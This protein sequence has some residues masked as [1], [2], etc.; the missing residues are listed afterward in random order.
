MNTHPIFSTLMN[1]L[2]VSLLSVAV[3][4]SVS[5]ITPVL[6]GDVQAAESRSEQD[7]EIK[8][9]VKKLS[10]KKRRVKRAQTM[11]PKIFKKLDK[12]RELADA[13]DYDGAV[14][15]LQSIEK[16]RRNSYETAMT[17]NMFA[18]VYFNQENYAKAVAAYRQ[19]IGG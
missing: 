3:L 2:T 7:K 5:A 13:K 8:K 10:S 11:R 17:H 19:V 18:Y 14:I 16:I 12:V 1:K 15:A 6:V 9:P 4:Y